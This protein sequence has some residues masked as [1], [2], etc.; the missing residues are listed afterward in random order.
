MTTITGTSAAGQAAG[1]NA[2]AGATLDQ[3]A[4]LKL[5]TT[6]LTM[7]DPFNPMDNTQMVAQMAQFSQV[8]GIAEMNRSLQSLAEMMGKSRLGEAASWIGRSM[9]VMSDHAAPL[10]D[11]T[12]AGEVHLAEASEDVT[13]SFVDETGAVV[14][15][16]SM[17][18]RDKGAFAYSWNGKN[19]NGENVPGPLKVVVTANNADGKPI[20]T[21]AAAWTLVQS[22][23]SPASGGAA[24]LVTGLGT[25]SPEDA[26]RLA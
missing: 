11:G 17:G 18:A 22:I 3:N 6:Q 1:A 13:I 5:M 8:S 20:E 10:S 2:G 9:L 14:H 25:L 23:Q 19:T 21:A 15:S 12:Y 26:I 16:Q 4:F 24:G 7:Q